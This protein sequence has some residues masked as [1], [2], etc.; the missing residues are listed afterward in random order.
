MNTNTTK[1]ATKKV[2][3]VTHTAANQTANNIQANLCMLS[4]Y[5][6]LSAFFKLCK[7]LM[8]L[9]T[10]TLI[11]I[12][13]PATMANN[14]C[15]LDATDAYQHLIKQERQK[16]IQHDIRLKAININRASEAELTTLA[17]IGSKK[18]QAIILYRDTMGGF[19]TLDE[20][21]NV[22]GIGQKTIDKNRQRL[23]IDDGS[24]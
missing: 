18:A 7:R 22:K 19:A 3:Q 16:S 5:Q 4:F 12:N 10:I 15:F 14:Q 13:S 21:A 11:A 9:L 8:F 6:H 20:L 23:R 2:T 24:D 17:G 1:K